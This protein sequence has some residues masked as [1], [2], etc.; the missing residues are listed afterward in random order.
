MNIIGLPLDKAH[1]AVDKEFIEY[2]Y[3]ECRYN[4]SELAR[5]L[6]LSRGKVRTLLK[7]YYGTKYIK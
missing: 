4:Q 7:N 3:A 2:A 1:R 6:N 5:Q